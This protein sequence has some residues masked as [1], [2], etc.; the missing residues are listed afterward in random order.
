[1]W[2]GPC[3]DKGSK[4]DYFLMALMWEL[5]K[6][7]NT[8]S[9]PQYERPGEKGVNDDAPPC[10]KAPKQHA[11][12]RLKLREPASRP[13]LVYEAALLA[14]SQGKCFQKVD[15]LNSRKRPRRPGQGGTTFKGLPL[16]L[17]T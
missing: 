12:K 6:V 14:Y 10:S 8:A 3:T 9:Q 11:P 15:P 2:D 16:L 1:M 13:R 5:A 7:P 4:R 17:R